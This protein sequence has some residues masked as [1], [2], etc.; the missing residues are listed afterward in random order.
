[1]VLHFLIEKNLQPTAVCKNWDFGLDFTHCFVLLWSV[2]YCKF[3]LTKSP[4]S[5]SHETL[6][7]ITK[8]I[9]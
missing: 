3:G 8:K 6:G 7:D 4:T 1:M 9:S 5:A 2:I